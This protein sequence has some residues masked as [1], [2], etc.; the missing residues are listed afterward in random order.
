VVLNPSRNETTAAASIALP[1]A[2][3]AERHGTYVNVQNRIQRFTAALTPPGEAQADYTVLSAILAELDVVTEPNSFSEL[4]D[5]MV[6]DV[7]ALAGLTWNGLGDL[8][9]DLTTKPAALPATSS[10]KELSP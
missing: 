1:T 6:K 8:G 7:P 2:N 4:F 10:A 3:Y 5:R 9:V